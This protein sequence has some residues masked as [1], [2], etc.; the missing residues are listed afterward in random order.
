MFRSGPD[1]IC[2][3]GWRTSRLALAPIIIFGQRRTIEWYAIITY[4]T[5]PN[6]CLA[7]VRV[8][9]PVPAAGSAAWAALAGARPRTAWLPAMV[10]L[11]AVAPLTWVDGRYLPGR[12]PTYADCMFRCEHTSDAAG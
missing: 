11:T 6:P 12:L 2:S 5:D 9:A 1:I 7:W 4:I 10:G 3:S 8:Q